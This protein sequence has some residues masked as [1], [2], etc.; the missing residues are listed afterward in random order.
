MLL[1]F[2]A[3]T[4]VDALP[5]QQPGTVPAEKKRAMNKFDPADLFPEAKGHDRK[6]R[7][8]R[9]KK[10]ASPSIL[11]SSAPSGAEPSST[12]RK[13][14]RRRRTEEAG[15]AKSDTRLAS[16]AVT[17]PALSP[18]LGAIQTQPTPTAA[19]ERPSSPNAVMEGAAA[20]TAPPSK[21][22][23]ASGNSPASS[24]ETSPGRQP[25]QDSWL[26]L[27]V[28]L[29]LLLLVALALIFALAKLMKQFR[30]SVN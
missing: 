4:I 30:G 12:S 5:Q 13:N 8:K 10:S 24:S 22:L 20:L 17:A 28:I 2:G 3:A 9:D 1:I 15:S 7:A 6:E 18:S 27:P 29:A 11:A 21:P 26:S 25:Q 16:N 19:M 14:S 23:I